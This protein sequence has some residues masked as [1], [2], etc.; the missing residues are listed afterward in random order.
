MGEAIWT[1]RVTSTPPGVWTKPAGWWERGS[2]V[3]HPCL[4]SAPLRRSHWPQ[5]TV[6]MDE[7][8]FARVAA[9]FPLCR[10]ASKA[11][12]GKPRSNDS[13]AFMLDL[14]REILQL[15]RELLDG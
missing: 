15:E 8:Q 5:L 2:E 9:F 6:A 10:A 11:Y 1:P 3:H 7:P 14:E 12:T 4:L 13:S